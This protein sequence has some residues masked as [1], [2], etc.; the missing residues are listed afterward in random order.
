MSN[1][2]LLTFW[3]NSFFVIQEGLIVN[4]RERGDEQS[5][6]GAEKEFY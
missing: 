4:L 5:N 1:L 2:R 6:G 3:G